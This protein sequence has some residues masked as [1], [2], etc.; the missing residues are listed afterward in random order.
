MVVTR[1]Q[2]QGLYEVLAQESEVVA[3]HLSHVPRT[4]TYLYMERPSVKRSR[5]FQIAGAL[6]ALFG[7]GV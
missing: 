1:A 2:V 6:C 5:S 7:G 3:V 4:D